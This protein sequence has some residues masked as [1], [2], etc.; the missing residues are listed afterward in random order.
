MT[1]LDQDAR[2]VLELTRQARTPTDDDKARV[3]RLLGSALLL[4]ATSAHAAGGGAAS[5]VVGTTL[6]AKWAGV[7]LLAV[8]GG[9]GYAGWRTWQVPQ[10][11][12]AAAITAT[13]PERPSEPV[14]AADVPVPAAEPV[15]PDESP[16]KEAARSVAR[17]TASP[18][19]ASAARGT[20]PEELDLLHDA[21]AKWRAGNASAALG[22]LSEHRRR[23][24]R[25]MLGPE[26]DALTVL[27]LCATNR[28]AQAKQLAHRFLQT[29]QHSP[30]RTSVEESCGGK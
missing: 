26:R 19:R 27:S 8:A 28:T 22:L 18:A 16:D 24:P 3:E 14:R 15:T 17:P 12:T 1:E 9:A 5:K 20:L 10:E 6:A 4:G 29:A 7:A 11:S 23:F 2:R 13:A 25:S 30:L 21:Q